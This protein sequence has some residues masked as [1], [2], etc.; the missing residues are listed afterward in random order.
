[1]S[2]KEWI[3]KI[4]AMER[5]L[6]QAGIPLPEIREQL[7]VDGE[8]AQVYERIDG[9]SLARLLLFNPHVTKVKI[10]ELAL[11]FADSQLNIHQH[12]GISELPNQKELFKDVFNRLPQLTGEM[13][14]GLANLLDNLPGGNSVCHGDYHPY[15]VIIS[16]GGAKV[17]DWNNSHLGNPLEDVA[18]SLLI[19][20]GVEYLSGDSSNM[21]GYFKELYLKHYFIDNPQ[22]RKDLESWRPIVAAI[23]LADNISEIE[24]WLLEQI[25]TSY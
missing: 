24:E 17:I 10:E 1:M 25:R 14:T 5:A 13:K 8:T 15:N 18:R 6:Y 9:E 21:I 20:E 11:L 7:Q 2:P 22:Q 12:R 3:N 23:R 16:K 19:L 4:A